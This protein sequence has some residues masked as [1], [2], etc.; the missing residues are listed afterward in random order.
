MN[1]LL[2]FVHPA[3]GG[4]AVAAMAWV[5]SRGLLA[6]Q[7]APGAH[8]KR[9]AHARWGPWALAAVVTAALTGSATVAWVRDDLDLAASWHFW[10]GWAAAAGMSALAWATPR[11]MRGSTAVRT[12]HPWVGAAVLGLGVF[13]LIVG[14]E[15]LP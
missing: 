8:A 3:L 6:R 7:G 11:R 2:P 5:G 14:I 13:V 9:R 1:E 12:G 10:A 15:L 4:V